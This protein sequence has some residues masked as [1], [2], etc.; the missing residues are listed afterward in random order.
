M[1]TT[2]TPEAVA[3]VDNRDA[4]ADDAKALGRIYRNLDKTTKAYK[5]ASRAVAD[6]WVGGDIQDLR[7]ARDESQMLL[8]QVMDESWEAI[9]A[10]P[11]G[12]SAPGGAN[13]QTVS[14]QFYNRNLN[15]NLKLRITATDARQANKRSFG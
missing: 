6:G 7:H 9:N 8:D 1:T 5:K 14:L 4:T 3:V 13:R 15:R 10:L 11:S 2:E 12:T